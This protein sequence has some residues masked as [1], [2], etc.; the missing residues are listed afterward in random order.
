MADDE[1]ERPARIMVRGKEMPS[2]S[3]DDD[4]CLCPVCLMTTIIS[5]EYPEKR[6]GAM[7]HLGRCIKQKAG[8]FGLSWLAETLRAKSTSPWKI[9]IERRKEHD[10]PAR[11]RDHAVDLRIRAKD[12]ALAEK[13]I[14]ARRNFKE[15]GKVMTLK[16]AFDI[17]A[18]IERCSAKTVES[19]YHRALTQVGPNYRDT[20]AIARDFLSQAYGTDLSSLI[21]FEPIKVEEFPRMKGQRG[22]PPKIPKK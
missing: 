4:L 20:R 17:V 12:L 15:D 18:V 7:L 8:L 13:V 22:R 9:S 2:H 5:L 1:L 16:E 6:F 3:G 14:L 10:M 19:S 21:D 11:S